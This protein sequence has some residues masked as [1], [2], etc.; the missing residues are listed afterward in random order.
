MEKKYKERLQQVVRVLEELPKKKR[1][2]LARFM[3]CGTTAC[4]LGW[5]GDDPWFRR[6]GFKTFVL[7]GW[8]FLGYNISFAD[9]TGMDAAR[10]FFA[11]TTN[12]S[13]HL[14]ICGEY[15][16]DRSKRAVS[17]RITAFI[18]RGGRMP[19]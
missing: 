13:H 14:F 19:D 8:H 2:N 15:P 1:F 10:S 12:E 3:T 18:K 11:L 16:R 5:A 17:R 9:E 4:A 7:Q 6:R